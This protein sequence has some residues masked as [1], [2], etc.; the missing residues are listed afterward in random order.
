MKEPK[1][2]TK[3]KLRES[4]EKLKDFMKAATEGFLVYDSELILREI[5]DSALRIIGKRGE[6][7]IGKHILEI[8]P[9]L[10][11]TGRYNE[12]LNV[13][14]TG[15]PFN[16]DDAAQTSKFR[17]I[18]LS[19]NAFKLMGGLGMIFNDVTERRRAEKKL[20]EEKE[21]AQTYL[22]TVGV[23][24]LVLNADQTVQ[25]INRKGCEILEENESEIIGVNWIDKYIPENSREVVKREYNRFIKGE[26]E[27][28]EY[29]EEPLIKKNSEKRIIA[30]HN[31]ALKNAEGKIVGSLSSGQ[32]I[33]ERIEIEQKLK[34]SEEKHR[35]F[36]ETAKDFMH[37][38]DKKG[39]II[40]V[41]RDFCGYKKEELMKMH[42]IELIAEET[43]P[44][45]APE[46]KN[47]IK[48]G[49]INLIDVSCKRKDGTKIV[50]ELSV[51]AIYKTDGKFNGARGIFKDITERRKAEIKL[52]ES[53]EKWKA[54]VE[55]SPAHIMLL[56]REHKILSINRTAPDLTKEEVIGISAYTF[57]PQEFHQIARN[58]FNSVWETGE[59][60]TYSTKY[61][62]KEGDT[63]FFD[64]WIGPVFQS[65]KI[66]ALVSHSIDVTENQEAE[67]KLK[68]SEKKYREAYNRAEFYKDLFTH[69]INNI[70]QNI[71]SGI[72]L[73]EME[74]GVSEKLEKLKENISII[75]SQLT[76]GSKLVSNIRKLSK[77]EEEEISIKKVEIC[78]I[79][80]TSIAYVKNAYKDREIT[81]QVELFAKELY[82]KANELL[83]DLFENILI[84]AI[85]YH[86]SPIVEIL[87]KISREKKEDINYLK[88]EFIDNGIGIEDS[89]KK[90]VFQRG[91]NDQKS[92]HGMGLGLSL[93]QKIIDNYKGKIWVEDRVY[94]DYTKGSNFVILIP[95][96]L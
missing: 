28:F 51:V 30:W 49:R 53:E 23:I 75:K 62:T 46:L 8:T 31:R 45:Y 44:S 17:N 43:L 18:H 67:Q 68:K 86:E 57:T 93:V 52:K 1:K 61:I 12:Y 87:I 10:E 24:L 78:T 72:E 48:N 4:E 76:R 81:I 26:I 37:I 55:N 13:I 16:T 65:G 66:I 36:M 20:K 25:L 54:L 79:L 60:V 77:L 90:L 64:V 19:I 9:G 6:D 27:L 58:S 73:S 5:N 32:D 84:N 29:T 21:K 56:D 35:A 15:E 50:G 83:E 71:L 63:R 91:Y 82:V 47:L 74:I 42:I 92:V 96:V 95:E 85:K 2:S 22:D 38:L 41:N 34:E 88:M 40:Y 3:E 14:K 39:K 70:L 89:R 7:V 69:D 80:K 94:G 33:T 59:P 11:N